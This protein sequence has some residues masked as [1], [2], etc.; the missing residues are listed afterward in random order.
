MALDVNLEN[1]RGRSVGK[2]STMS[3]L[4]RCFC[5]YLIDKQ[6]QR[7]RGVSGPLEN[8]YTTS[9][10]VW[11]CCVSSSAANPPPRAC[12]RR[13]FALT[14][15]RISTLVKQPCGTAVIYV[16]AMAVQLPLRCIWRV[17]VVIFSLSRF[18]SDFTS[19]ARLLLFRPFYCNTSKTFVL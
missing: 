10:A 9:R 13:L 11:R 16:R 3:P 15:Y 5:K 8:I 17:L 4:T 14:Q 1:M 6:I 18:I 2:A 7:L 12:K 19:L